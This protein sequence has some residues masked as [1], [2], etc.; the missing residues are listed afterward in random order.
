MTFRPLLVAL[1]LVGGCGEAPAPTT[2]GA[3]PAR[4]TMAVSDVRTTVRGCPVEVS[5]SADKTGFTLGE[6]VFL[7]F[8]VTTTCGEELAVID[9]GDYRNR[10]GRPDSFSVSALDASGD[11][12]PVTA[13]DAGFQF[14]GLMGPQ[15][16]PFEKRLL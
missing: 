12:T 6:P 10:L 13:V 7:T 16:L 9:G 3:T 1:A 5:V 14:G 2:E 11:G 8:R 15:P 4:T